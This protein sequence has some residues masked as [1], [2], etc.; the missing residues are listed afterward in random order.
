MQGPGLNPHYCEN[1][2][3][4]YVMHMQLVESKHGTLEHHPGTMGVKALKTGGPVCVSFYKGIQRVVGL[5]ESM[6]NKRSQ[7]EEAKMIPQ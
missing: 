3:S 5:K 2:K 6:R 1:M 4:R 7:F